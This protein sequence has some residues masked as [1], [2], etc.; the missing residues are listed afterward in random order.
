MPV[1]NRY[2][3]SPPLTRSLSKAP[4]HTDRR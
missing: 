4:S 2:S 3:V 1:W